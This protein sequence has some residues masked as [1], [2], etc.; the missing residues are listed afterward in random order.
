[1]LGHVKVAGKS[2][3]IIAIPKL[4][5]LLA[6]EGAIITIDVMGC[7]RNIA[8]KRRR[9]T[10][11]D[12]ERQSGVAARR[13]GT[14]RGRAKAAKF[15]DTTISSERTVDG[16]NGSLEGRTTTVIHDVAWLQERHD[17]PGLKAV[18]VVESDRGIGDK[19][20]RKTRLHLTSMRLVA[21]L[22]A[23]IIRGH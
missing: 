4:L 6:I 3:E 1:M 17:W 20:E 8:R 18:V 7:Q 15:A 10:M 23:P 9:P 16:D 14:V 11:S 12:A 21:S 2:N 19:I 22:L 13:R 5:H